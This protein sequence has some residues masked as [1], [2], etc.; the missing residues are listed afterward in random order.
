M[1]RCLCEERC[2]DQRQRVS[3]TRG[4]CAR[5]RL[6]HSR[7][8]PRVQRPGRDGRQRARSSVDVWVSL[9]GRGS[10]DAWRVLQRMRSLHSQAETSSLTK[11]HSKRTAEHAFYPQ[12]RNG[13]RTLPTERAKLAEGSPVRSAWH[14]CVRQP[15]RALDRRR[16]QRMAVRTAVQAAATAC[17]SAR[18]A[19]ESCGITSSHQGHSGIPRW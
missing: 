8:G 10:R 18:S 4:G 3:R 2:G 19:L 11:R 9:C 17:T 12:G 13:T 16:W 6:S 14:C 5:R 1:A 7:V 15:V